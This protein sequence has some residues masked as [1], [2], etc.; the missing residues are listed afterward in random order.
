MFITFEGLDFSGKSTQA[1]LFV[2]RLRERGTTVRVLREPGGTELSERVRALLLERS[3]E[4]VHMLSEILLFEASRAQLV[5]QI[6]RP[7]LA[8]GETVVCDR[9]Y[10]SSTAYQ[11]FG[12]GIP[13]DTVHTLNAIATGRLAPDLTFLLDIPVREIARRQ[14]AAG[15]ASDRM[16]SAG[17]DF[18]QRVRNGFLTLVTSEPGRV[19]RVD[20]EGEPAAVAATVWSAFEAKVRRKEHV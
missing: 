15:V 13:L 19:V 18:Y 6:I 5:H 12:R 7:A 16:E 14:A 11:G 9:Y 4:P 20:G 10:D 8:R 17:T 2:D 1:R 3:T